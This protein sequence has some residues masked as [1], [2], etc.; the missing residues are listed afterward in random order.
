[1]ME[2]I[3]TSIAVIVTLIL[4]GFAIDDTDKKNRVYTEYV[5]LYRKIQKMGEEKA[6]YERI[7]EMHKEIEDLVELSEEKFKAGSITF[8][9]LQGHMTLS[10]AMKTNLR[11]QM[12]ILDDEMQRRR[13]I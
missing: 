10:Q 2:I 11:R 9:T 7:E 3:F 13:K 5:K 4:I 8:N 1:M 6:P 12:M